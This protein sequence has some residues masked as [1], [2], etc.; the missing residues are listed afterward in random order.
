LTLSS[1]GAILFI[2]F[3]FSVLHLGAAF[4][5]TPSALLAQ[6]VSSGLSTSND[7]GETMS[8]SEI[9]GVVQHYGSYP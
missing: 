7:E 4:V 1:Y 2:I 6:E 3:D 9:L 5:T 8:S